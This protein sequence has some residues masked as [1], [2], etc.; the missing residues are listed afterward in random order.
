MQ[1]LRKVKLMQ[2]PFGADYLRG[3]VISEPDGNWEGEAVFELH[4]KSNSAITAEGFGVAL[5]NAT[6]MGI[7]FLIA[8]TRDKNSFTSFPS[9]NRSI[10]SK[11]NVRWQSLPE[12]KDRSFKPDECFC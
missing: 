8:S 3:R 7:P 9:V 6:Q 11:H 5:L 4:F 12:I 10:R 1:A 2:A